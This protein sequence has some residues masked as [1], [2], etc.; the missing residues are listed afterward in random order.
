MSAETWGFVILIILIAILL[1]AV[2]FD[3]LI[4][5]PREHAERE[6]KREIY[7]NSP[8]YRQISA[9]LDRA[10]EKWRNSGGWDENRDRHKYKD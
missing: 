2:V 8:E 5:Q 10:T 7:Y 6:R 9:D 3:E 1:A 4:T